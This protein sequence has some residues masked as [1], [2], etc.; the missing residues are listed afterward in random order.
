MGRLASRLGMDRATLGHNLR[1]LMARGLVAQSIGSD[2]RARPLLLTSDGR[3]ALAAALPGWRAAQ[4]NFENR[5][6]A[7]AAAE[8]RG[9]MH[10]VA[11][12]TQKTP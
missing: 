2:R 11:A 12:L 6:G 1:P 9:I 10:R 5:F 4:E 8:M 7:A 3:A